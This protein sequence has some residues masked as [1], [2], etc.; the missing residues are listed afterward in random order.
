M[1]LILFVAKFG[2]GR[3]RVPVR[4]LVSCSEYG[5]DYHRTKTQ[6]FG[7]RDGKFPVTKGGVGGGGC[8]NRGQIKKLA[9]R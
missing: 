7:C 8:H 4:A 6:C 3:P 2:E 5:D 1:I 9:Q